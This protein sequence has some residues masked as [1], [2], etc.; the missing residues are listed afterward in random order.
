M[1][2]VQNDNGGNPRPQIALDDGYAKQPI[3]K[4][5]DGN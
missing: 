5:G 3:S 1:A 2:Q 4:K